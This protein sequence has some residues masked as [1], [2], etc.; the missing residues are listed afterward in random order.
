MNFNPA[1][2]K[3]MGQGW[4]FETTDAVWSYDRAIAPFFWANYLPEKLGGDQL[5]L[6]GLRDTKGTLLSGK[7]SYRLRVPADVP[8]DKFWS[9]IV[10]SQKTKSFI[11]NPLNRIGRLGRRLVE[12]SRR[13][14]KQRQCRDGTFSHL[15]SCNLNLRPAFRPGQGGIAGA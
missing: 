10:Y 4:S 5:Y 3:R 9:A 15:L 8:V 1:L 14:S 2:L 12:P 7:N 11:A 13:L 6:M